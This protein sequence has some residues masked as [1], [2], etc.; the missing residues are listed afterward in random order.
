MADGVSDAGGW[1]GV[2]HDGVIGRE[3]GGEREGFATELG[4]IKGENGALGGGDHAALDGD[5]ERVVVPDAGFGDAGAAEDGEVG[6]NLAEGLFAEGADEDAEAVV[7]GA[8][9]DDG[10]EGTDLA[11]EAGDGE[12]VGDDLETFGDKEAGDGVGG[13]AAV[14]NDGHAGLDEV[15]DGAGDGEFFGG[16]A[17]VAGDE[18]VFAGEFVGFEEGGAAVVTAKD[19]FGGE[20]V[21][22]AADGGEGDA[23]AGG[24]GM[25]VGV[26]VFAEVVFDEVEALL[27]G[28]ERGRRANG[29]RP[30]GGGG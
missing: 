15:G 18:V 17:F 13:G 21:E 6:M 3:G 27:V 12:G 23:E 5:D 19:A 16:L 26:F 29:F 7:D 10:F 2:G 1:N 9:G 20:F 25:E 22:G 24:E 28:H 11:E 4:A 14:E 8:A 30:I